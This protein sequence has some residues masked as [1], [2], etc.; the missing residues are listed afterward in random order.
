MSTTEN[1]SPD[2]D[3]PVWGAKSIGAQIGR[4]ERQAFHLLERGL[5]PAEKIGKIWVTTPR[6]LRNHIAGGE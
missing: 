5:I 2:L 4:N 6:R 3:T 1:P